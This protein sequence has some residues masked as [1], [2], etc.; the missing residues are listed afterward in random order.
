M[1]ASVK[2]ISDYSSELARKNELEKQ[3]LIAEL[4]LLMI[5]LRPHFLFNTLNNLYSMAI[6]GDKTTAAGISKIINLLKYILIE[7][8]QEKVELN[9]EINLIEDY[10][11]LEKI[12]YDERLEF[13]FEKE[14]DDSSLLIAPMI[15]FTFVENCFKHGSGPA[16]GKSFI[17][18]TLKCNN[19]LLEFRS[20]NSVPTGNFRNSGKGLGLENVRKRLEL[21]Y[22]L[23]YKLNIIHKD[24]VFDVQLKLSLNIN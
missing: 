6:V 23:R 24:Q 20:R 8:D 14:I 22:P 2:Y 18:I 21:L 5:Q 4:S 12:R 19:G 13:K 15:L 10:V 16:H 7:Y 11:E 17:H 3:N 1:F 9:K